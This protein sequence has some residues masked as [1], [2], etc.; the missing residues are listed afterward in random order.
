MFVRLN[1]VSASRIRRAS[2]TATSGSPRVL[3]CIDFDG[4]LPSIMGYWTMN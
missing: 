3:V 1:D 4:P 2:C